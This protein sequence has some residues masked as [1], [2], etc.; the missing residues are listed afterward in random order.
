MLNRKRPELKLS[1]ARKFALFIGGQALLFAIAIFLVAFL[2][3]RNFIRLTTIKR[4]SAVVNSFALAMESQI[5][6]KNELG[7]DDVTSLFG[8]EE[9]VVAAYVTDTK[10]VYLSH[11]GVGLVGTKH[12]LYEIDTSVKLSEKYYMAYNLKRQ[13]VY[14]FTQGIGDSHIATIEVPYSVVQKQVIIFLLRFSVVFLV[15][16][17]LSILAIYMIVRHLVRPIKEL[18][19]GAE[20]IGSGNFNHKIKVL[21]KDEIGILT[22]QFNRMTGRIRKA[23]E[24]KIAQERLKNELE[25]ASEIQQK[26]IP[27]K[28]L[29]FSEYEII[30][31]YSPAKEIGGDYF[32]FFPLQ[33]KRLGFV[34]AD[35]SGKGVPAALVM[36]MLKTIFTTLTNVLFSAKEILVIANSQLR[37]SVKS[38]VFAAVTFGILDREKHLIEYAMAGSEKIIHFNRKTGNIKLLKTN[39]FPLGIENEA[40]FSSTLVPNTITLEKGDGL[41]LYTDGLTDVKNRNDSYFGLEGISDFISRFDFANSKDFAKKL[42]AETIKF[43]GSPKQE[44]DLSFILVLRK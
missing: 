29:G 17:L 9:N 34:M 20:I 2:S 4:Y 21:S 6:Q 18:T 38:G 30:H 13:L 8:K 36:S 27:D 15:V 31:Y 7:Y 14:I 11:S 16:F 1:L 32:D 26:L 5:A 40:N 37:R 28:P 43:R 23:Q 44:D 3:E 25:I 33:G 42:V 22:D 12:P 10:G 24:M 39:G 19:H 41:F 35:V